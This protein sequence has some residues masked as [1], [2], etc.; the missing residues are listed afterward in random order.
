MGV[1]T[2]I[3]LTVIY[4]LSLGAS[5]NILNSS[6][7]APRGIEHIDPVRDF[8]FK[9]PSWQA[10]IVQ[11][12]LSLHVRDVDPPASAWF[13][14]YEKLVAHLLPRILFVA[15]C[16]HGIFPSEQNMVSLHCH[17]V[18]I[19]KPLPKVVF[20]FIPKVHT[21]LFSAPMSMRNGSNIYAK[22]IIIRHGTLFRV[23]M[24]PECHT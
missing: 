21:N 16:N 20:L 6:F 22:W 15:R 10:V 17:L 1:T 18:A 14:I 24:L 19:G 23:L 7:I 3:H 13:T 9:T 12:L 11:G 2:E 8:A 4:L 5:S